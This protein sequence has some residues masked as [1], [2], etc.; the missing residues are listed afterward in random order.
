MYPQSVVARDPVAATVA[1]AT[2]TIEKIEAIERTY[3]SGRYL[4]AYRALQDAGLMAVGPATPLDHALLVARVRRACGASRGG[5]KLVLDTWRRHRRHPRAAIHAIH[6]LAQAGPLA[7][8]D[9]MDRI[10][11]LVGAT[12]EDEADWLCARALWLGGLRDF[13]AAD[14]AWRAARDR[15][16]GAWLWSVRAMIDLDRDR[17]DAALDAIAEAR[18]LH[19]WY[20]PAIDVAGRALLRA[21]RA[22]E[23]RALL[24]EA[25][26]HVEALSVELALATRHREAG[27]LDAAA[28]TLLR[29]VAVAPAMERDLHDLLCHALGHVHYLRGDAAL[30]ADLL[31]RIDDDRVRADAARI[32]AGT[33][34]RRLLPVPHVPQDHHTCAP[35]TLTA[36]AEHWGAAV[37]HAELAEQ[38]CHD[39]T[40]AGSER[41]WAEER[42]FVSRQL[43]VTWDA[44]RALIDAGVPI[45]LTTSYT[46]GGH[47]QPVAGYDERRRTLLIV[48][49]GATGLVEADWDR[50]A[51]DQ[52][53]FGPRGM[54][55]VPAAE[56]HRLDGVE[57]PDAARYDHLFAIE[58][59]LQRHDRAAA[60]AA[61]DALVAAAPAGHYLRHQAR[62][63]LASY[64]GDARGALAWVEGLRASFPDHAF[65]RLVELTSRRGHEADEV[66]A[67]L[68][69]TL[70]VEHRDDAAIQVACARFLAGVGD[71][72]AAMACARRALR[73]APQH[74]PAYRC[75]ADLTWGEGDRGRA[76]ALYRAASCLAEGDEGAAWSYFSAA[77]IA[78]EVEAALAHL[79]DRV[80]R[81]AA[82]SGGP[83]QTLCE[84][85]TAIG[86]ATEGLALLEQAIAAHPDDGDLQL[87]AAEQHR[88]AG[89]LAGAAA[90]LAAARGKVP[91][92][93][94]R[95]GAAVLAAQRGALA[96]AIALR[97]ALTE[98]DPLDV[99]SPRAYVD[100]L[101]RTG[102]A[103]VARAH[104]VAASA[105]HPFH[106]PLA[107]LAADALRR[108]DRGAARDHL[109][110]FVARQPRSA[111][112]LRRLADHHAVAGDL[113]AARAMLERARAC[114]DD[115]AWIDAAEAALCVRE[116]H[117]DRAI[118][119]LRAAI[120]RD[121]DA[122]GA[123][124]DLLELAGDAAEATR[125]LDEVDAALTR[126]GS[127][128]TG[129]LAYAEGLR[130]WV[131]RPTA[132]A[133]LR[134]LRRARGHQWH[135][136]AAEI[137]A[138]AD[139]GRL[140][141]AAVVAREAT[142]RFGHEPRP[143]RHLAA[144][145][146]ARDRADAA[147][148]ALTRGVELHPHATDL[149][150]KLVE[151][152]VAAGEVD[153]ARARL[154]RAIAEDPLEARNHGF[155]A[156]ALDKGGDR[157]GA[158]DALGRALALEPDYAWAWDQ[159]LEWS[160][161]A[162][163]VLA[164]ARE[165]VAAAATAVEPRLVLANHD[166]DLA[167][168]DRLALFDDASRIA[169]E[170]A[171]I[172]DHKV[173]LLA[174]HERWDEALAACRP[175]FWGDVPPVSLRGR[176]AWLRYQRGWRD[177][178]IADMIE[179]VRLTPSYGWGIEQ[180]IEWGY[181]AG[182][183]IAVLERLVA[184]A[185]RSARAHA[186]LGEAR[187]VA[188]DTSGAE[189]SLRRAL[190]LD[191]TDR[192]ARLALFDI[193]FD[194][195]DH[196]AAAPLLELL[197]RDD[198]FVIARRIQLAAAAG[199]RDDA[200]RELTRMLVDL[201][202]DNREAVRDA[203]V[204]YSQAGLR[205]EVEGVL[206][207]LLRRPDA[208]GAVGVAW[209]NHVG[210]FASFGRWRLLRRLPHSR[211][212]R[213]V[214]E[215][216]VG[217]LLASD[218]VSHLLGF[219]LFNYRR[220]RRWPALWGV[221]GWALVQR[222]HY[223]LAERWMGDHDRQDGLAGW[224]LGHLARALIGRGD[225][226]QAARVCR[227]ALALPRDG[228]TGRIRLLLAP[229][230]ALDNPGDARREVAAA[231]TG[232]LDGDSRFLAAV[233]DALVVY[234]QR[235][236]GDP[237]RRDDLTRTLAELWARPGDRP[238]YIARRLYDH[239]VERLTRVLGRDGEAWRGQLRRLPFGF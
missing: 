232:E 177:A 121:V 213:V 84:V 125:L 90:R 11:P 157:A 33:G 4:T 51:A 171:D 50:L 100:L 116:G 123:V 35:A 180:V 216:H 57:L 134:A 46:V 209:W 9:A 168:A 55:F 39:G 63:A 112:A 211:A 16:V 158:R 235:P 40:P 208:P 85:H 150:R 53:P 88:L 236:D 214:L 96:E 144:V 71:V 26:R 163:P 23:A 184:A 202:V 42:G 91:E 233:T 102:A 145:E 166:S 164:R 38:I 227:R 212:A 179:V 161:D 167:L 204:G 217:A 2:G 119:C 118:A 78:G 146:L 238:S 159:L 69:A 198:P 175:A 133:R 192:L 129:L 93:V 230:I 229:M 206:G 149:V 170:R 200:D 81:M 197:D 8:L 17:P 136:W 195:G 151:V 187:R 207:A 152:E 126:Q 141:D 87:V 34:V 191:A 61:Y 228:M 76:T 1:E 176:A 94:W 142:E 215:Q 82:R 137:D 44:A 185:P 178:A 45:A 186:A 80:E 139:A 210:R 101:E 52:A 67:A 49:P 15:H 60:Q 239:V 18:A 154:A 120:A 124:H 7:A 25:S 132:L 10:G 3:Q 70:Q 12:A 83:A 219:A 37:S 72:A 173:V 109:E 29:A 98:D 30:A 199:R 20:R 110:A 165:A 147:R 107:E 135:A 193:V 237:G 97:R 89:D 41:R 28:A 224:M 31:R 95:R 122:A 169:P 222:G 105:A 48:E 153:V 59:A 103:D 189:A 43:T 140:D 6:E 13:L 92:P 75:L 79:R 32:A 138:L 174:H 64:D 181:A 99:G 14:A 130:R 194:N 196:A 162:A 113:V 108:H 223:W 131:D 115:R 36:I 225:L 143:W 160:D 19:P 182:T 47:L 156:L 27:D 128:G 190:D 106:I 205:V 203:V 183:P 188:G 24:A 201:E 66:R 74:A 58:V 155:L 220:A 22:A 111:W 117:R 62:R 114:A 234:A 5:R 218:R 68:V 77:L 172:W 148:A 86:R 226:A 54:V 73:V 221:V 127:S 104:A 56:A 231:R 21:R 65:L